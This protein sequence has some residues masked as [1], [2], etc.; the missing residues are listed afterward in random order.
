M[1][2]TSTTHFFTFSLHDALPIYSIEDYAVVF[3]P[4]TQERPP[5]YTR[6]FKVDLTTLANAIGVPISGRAHRDSVRVIPPGYETVRQNKPISRL[7]NQP[8]ADP[9]NHPPT[10]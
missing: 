6:T 5:L 4:R 7:S 2:V 8:A 1:F 3:S 9:R 10:N